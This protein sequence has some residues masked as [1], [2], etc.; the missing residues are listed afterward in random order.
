MTSLFAVHNWC[1]M[2]NEKVQTDNIYICSFMTGGRNCVVENLSSCRHKLVQHVSFH[3]GTCRLCFI[4]PPS[5]SLSPYIFAL[6]PLAFLSGFIS[7]PHSSP[8]CWFYCIKTERIGQHN[9]TLR[10]PCMPVNFVLFKRWNAEIEGKRGGRKCARSHFRQQLTSRKWA[11]AICNLLWCSFTS[12]R[13][14]LHQWQRRLQWG[15]ALLWSRKIFRE[16]APLQILLEWGEA[17]R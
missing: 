13:H 1:G 5:V 8:A 2:T 16:R 4:S 11:E 6:F 15:G 10:V 12:R 9:S 7:S 3:F 14:L 17:G